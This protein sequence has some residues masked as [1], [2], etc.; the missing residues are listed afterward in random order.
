MRI[1]AHLVETM[2]NQATTKKPDAEWGDGRI[3]VVK[4]WPTIRESLDRG[5]SMARIYRHCIDPGIISYSQFARL[6]AKGLRS[7]NLT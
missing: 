7:E 6:V 1:Y 4:K 2:Q 3:E 5:W